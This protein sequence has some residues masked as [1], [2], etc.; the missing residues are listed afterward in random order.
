MSVSSPDPAK[1]AAAALRASGST[2]T[3]NLRRGHELAIEVAS[4]LASQ[5]CSADHT[6]QA[7]SWLT[8]SI[9]DHEQG[10][11]RKD[12]AWPQPYSLPIP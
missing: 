8:A 4:M 3:G 12:Q 1:A 6:A 11:A 10:P 9:R 7:L 5:L 2:A